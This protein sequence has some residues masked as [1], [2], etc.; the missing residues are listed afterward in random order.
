MLEDIPEGSRQFPLISKP[1]QTSYSEAMVSDVLEAFRL[2][3]YHQAL[4]G[5]RDDC[6][7]TLD[8]K[9]LHK[10]HQFDMKA[11]DLHNA[12]SAIRHDSSY[13]TL[14][15]HDGH[16]IMLTPNSRLIRH[17]ICN[18][19]YAIV[20]DVAKSGFRTLLPE[21]YHEYCECPATY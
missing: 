19:P 20:T 13:A 15:D 3:Y 7:H 12:Y 1:F 17:A 6:L 5:P 11:E 2:W 9:F 10:H 16:N 21:L 8:S 18:G 4:L 14:S